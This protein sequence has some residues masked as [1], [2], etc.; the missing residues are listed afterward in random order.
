MLNSMKTSIWKYADL[1]WDTLS[2]LKAWFRPDI[3]REGFTL[4]NLNNS[5]KVVEVKNSVNQTVALC[6][7]ERCFIVQQIVNP[8][9]TLIETGRA[10]DFVDQQLERLAQSEGMERFLIALPSSYPSQP[11]EVWVRVISRQVPQIAAMQSID[12]AAQAHS[13]LNN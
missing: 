10:G 11:D 7:I 8:Q 4:E 12:G 5:I 3:A 2:K 9:A 1:S 6:P 13:A